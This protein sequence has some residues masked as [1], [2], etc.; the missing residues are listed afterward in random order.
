MTTFSVHLVGDRAL[1]ARI[2]SM[3][4]AVHTVLLRKIHGLAL[5]LQAHIQ[6]DKLSG[7][8]LKVQTGALRRSIHTNVIDGGNRIIGR[9]LSSGD[10]K[11]AG[12]HEFGGRTPP[13]E[14]RPRKADALH[15]MMGGKAVFAKVVKHPGSVMPERSFMRSG[16]LDMQYTIAS[17]MK[18]AVVQGLLQAKNGGARV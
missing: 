10:V 17:E 7:Q 15:F 18:E 9:V 13:H 4:S 8:V 16:L 3:P 12:I 11:Y 2:D 5:R 1:V 6:R 14:I